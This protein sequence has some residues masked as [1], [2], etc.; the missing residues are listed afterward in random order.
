MGLCS[1]AGTSLA[2]G[3]TLFSGIPLR[4]TVGIP[5]RETVGVPLRETVGVPLRETV[6]S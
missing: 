4:K 3:C 5:L 2:G 6:L 1:L